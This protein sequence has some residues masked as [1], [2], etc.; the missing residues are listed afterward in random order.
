MSLREMSEI[1]DL[2]MHIVSNWGVFPGDLEL[3]RL[4]LEIRTWWEKGWI[5]EL[6]SPEGLEIRD[7]GKNA[8]REMQ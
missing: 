7:E 1:R 4:T 3:A 8:A 5:P 2:I 6:E